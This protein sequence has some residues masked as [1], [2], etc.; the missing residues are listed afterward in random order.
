MAAGAFFA[1][2]DFGVNI[3]DVGRDVG[4]SDA[5]GLEALGC[6]AGGEGLDFDSVTGV[7]G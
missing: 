6:A 1:G 7:D 5:E 2:W 3:G 4:I